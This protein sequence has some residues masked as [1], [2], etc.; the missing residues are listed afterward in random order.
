MT[1]SEPMT[2]PEPSGEELLRATS[3]VRAFTS[4][5]VDPALV[6][7]LLDE[8]RFAPSGGNR[9]PWRVVVLD[10]RDVRRRLGE[11]MQPVWDDYIAA[12]A[13]GFM[14]FNVVDGDDAPAG[15]EHTSNAL[16]DTIEEVPVV[17]VVAA[18]LRSVAVMD[19]SLER[20]PMTGGASIYPFCWSIL[21]AAHR[22]GLGGVLTTF[23][24]R[25]EPAAAPLLGLPDDHALAATMFLGWPQ[26]RSTRLTRRAV[27]EFTT[28][29]RFDGGTFEPD[30]QA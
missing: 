20:I 1:A 6:H 24:S 9:Q 10:D 21:L 27:A 11:L 18:D 30:A 12:G 16:L 5:P 13:A 14:P 17:L 8:A 25:V 23:L 4:D 2:S 3:A 19:G 28:I 15:T 29:D 22:R 7:E 26:H